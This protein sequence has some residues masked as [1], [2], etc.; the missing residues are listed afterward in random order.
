[1]AKGTKHFVIDAAGAKHTRTSQNRKYSHT[2][3][4]QDSY[5]HAKAM[6]VSKDWRTRDRNN[7][8][9]YMKWVNGSSE[10]ITKKSWES[11]E[12]HAERIA[13]ETANAT[14]RLNGCRDVDGYLAMQQAQRLADVEQKKAEG[15]FDQWC[16]AGWCGRRDLAEK[17]AAQWTGPAY[18]NTT[19]LEA[20]VEA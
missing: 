3:V 17:L 20:Q 10:Y 4:Y 14:E 16:N 19:I 2:V 8:D 5:E 1:M 12:Q 11:D 9:F 13:R 7:F 6:A 18:R 15:G